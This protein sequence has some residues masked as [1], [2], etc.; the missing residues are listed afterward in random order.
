MN[1]VYASVAHCALK[2]WWAVQGGAGQRAACR[3]AACTACS[4]RA[5]RTAQ[6]A[7]HA[8][9]A[10]AA[11][12]GAASGTGVASRMVVSLLPLLAPLAVL[13]HVWPFGSGC[14]APSEGA[15]QEQLP[16]RSGPELGSNTTICW[17]VKQR[18]S[19]WNTEQNRKPWGSTCG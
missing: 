13:P 19:L 6:R 9:A 5:A 1:G 11:G 16:C 15:P 4:S 10:A 18:H 12:G 2:A 14:S 3:G 8:L 17:G 7:R